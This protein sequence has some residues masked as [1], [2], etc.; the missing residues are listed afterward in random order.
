M[1]DAFDSNLLDAA[2]GL[3]ESANLPE[4]TLA[5][6]KAIVNSAVDKMSQIDSELGNGMPE[7]T[8]D[9]IRQEAV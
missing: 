5:N 8:I 7:F 1:F 2:E 9:D 4:D 3:R 6:L